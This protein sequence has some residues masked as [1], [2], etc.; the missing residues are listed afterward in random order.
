LKTV[1][2]SLKVVLKAASEFLFLL[3]FATI[4]QF[5]LVCSACHSQLTEKFFVSQAAFTATFRVTGGYIK[6]GTSLLKRITGR[7]FRISYFKEAN[8]NFFLLFYPQKGSQILSKS[9]VFILGPSS[10]FKPI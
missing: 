9:T 1:T 6:A 2:S 10:K 4:S 8:R 7:I 5:S 3:S